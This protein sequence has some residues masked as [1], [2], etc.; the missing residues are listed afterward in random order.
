MQ[1]GVEI[2]ASARLDLEFDAEAGLTKEQLDEMAIAL[3][4]KAL[5]DDPYGVIDAIVLEDIVP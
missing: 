2:K 1:A 5:Q 3:F 4:V